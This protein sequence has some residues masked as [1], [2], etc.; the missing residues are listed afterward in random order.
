MIESITLNSGLLSDLIKKPII[1]FKE[2]LNVIIG[3]NGCGKSLLLK[4]IADECYIDNYGASALTWKRD[5]YSRLSD[6]NLQWSGRD[7]FYLDNEY[8]QNFNNCVYHLNGFSL[9]NLEIH[10]MNLSAGQ[11]NTYIQNEL[12]TLKLDSFKETLHNYLSTNHNWELRKFV[13]SKDF[14]GKATILLDELDSHLDLYQ[15]KYFHTTFLP[16]LAMKFQVICVSHS[17][18]ALKHEN[19][20]LLSEKIEY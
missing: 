1:T 15:Q 9:S 14:S 16:L 10:K 5:R 13:A 2:G 8:M 20:I 7:V 18:F 11:L 19:I 17:V 6:T 12:L 3:K 4:T